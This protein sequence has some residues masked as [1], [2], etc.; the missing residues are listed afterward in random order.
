M[1]RNVLRLVEED[2]RKDEK[3]ALF[4]RLK[5][6]SKKLDEL[7]LKSVGDGDQAG[8]EPDDLVQGR[9]EIFREIRSLHNQFKENSMSE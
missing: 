4:K 9:K 5:A 7:K 3:V 1:D 2:R 8:G 6:L